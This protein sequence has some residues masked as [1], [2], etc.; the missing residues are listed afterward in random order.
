MPG[1]RESRPST[2]RPTRRKLARA[3]YFRYLRGVR[4][5]ARFHPLTVRRRL[6]LGRATILA[7]VLGVTACTPKYKTPED[8]Y[9]HFSTAVE[10]RDGAAL[11]D[12]LDQATR[13]AWMTVQK[14]HRE[15]YDIVISNY[16]Q[17]PERER[18]LR[19]FEKGATAPSAREL[20]KSEVAPELLPKLASLVVKQTTVEIE[21]PGDVAEIV[22]PQG[23][24]VRFARGRN[25]GW[26]FAG[27]APDAEARKTRAYHDLEQVRA[28]AADYERAAARGAR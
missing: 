12:A 26:G 27:L 7:L 20:F 5:V 21:A 10:T 2:G 8:A 24:R 13:W 11:F 25:G 23:G 1:P 9:A 3:P 4:G 16:P 14:W 15:A 6:P 19:R 17:G 22:L 18:E 28:N